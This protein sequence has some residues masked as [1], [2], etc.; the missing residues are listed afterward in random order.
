MKE[1][2]RSGVAFLCH[3][4]ITPPAPSAQQTWAQAF[5]GGQSSSSSNNRLSQYFEKFDVKESSYHLLISRLDL[6]ICDDSQSR[7]PGTS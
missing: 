3:M 5:G 2:L 6:H 4:Q 7:E 1:S